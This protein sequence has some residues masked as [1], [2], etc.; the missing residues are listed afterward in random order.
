MNEKQAKRMRKY[1]RLAFAA[2]RKAC[3]DVML[4]DVQRRVC[5]EWLKLPS[6]RARGKASARVLDVLR[7]AGA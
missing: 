3:E 7:V 1:A 6:H 5:A 4:L 2:S